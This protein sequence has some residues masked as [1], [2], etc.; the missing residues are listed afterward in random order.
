MTRTDAWGPLAGIKVI[1]LAGAGGAPFACMLLAD[2]GA[3]VLRIDRPSTADR[4]GGE[5]IEPRFNVMKRGRRSVVIDLK[6]P[7]GV[8][9]LL[10]LI[11]RADVLIEAYRPGVAERL[12]IGPEACAAINRGLVYGRITG[13]GQDGPLAQVA[14]HDIN[15]I[16]LAGALDAI[17]PADQGPIPPLNLLGDFGG[18]AMY[19]AFGVLCA[20]VERGRSGEG[21]VVDAAMVDGAASMMSFAY[22]L[23]AAGRWAESRGANLFDGGAPWY[24]S[25]RTLDDKYVC[26]G[27]FEAPFYRELTARIGLAAKEFP[28]QFDRSAWPAMRARFEEIFR[29]KTSAEWAGLLQDVDVCFTPVLSMREA[30]DHPHNIARS[31]FVTVDGVTQPAP[32]PRLS[33]T[34]GRVG[35]APIAPGAGAQDTLRD[36]GL[37]A[38]EVSALEQRGAFGAPSA[39]HREKDAR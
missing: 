4:L 30:I 5:P 26:I 7:A 19:L 23:L 17:G 21:Q 10:R 1:E 39:N 28:D 9:A 33:R 25:Y 13:W 15:F 20:L 24:A 14:G 38:G 3:E 16:A 22:G 18:G 29:G 12:G 32:A 6:K 31:T 36:W 11:A 35:A 37:E 34:P 8:E 27:P 2:M